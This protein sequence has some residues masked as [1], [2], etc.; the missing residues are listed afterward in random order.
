MSEALE[1]RTKDRPHHSPSIPMQ[2]MD[3][4]YRFLEYEDLEWYIKLLIEKGP[5]YGALL[6]LKKTKILTIPQDKSLSCLLPEQRRSLRR[7]L[8]ILNVRNG[9]G[10]HILRTTPPST[11]PACPCCK[12]W[13]H[14]ALP[15]FLSPS[16]ILEAL[17]LRLIPSS[18]IHALLPFHHHHLIHQTIVSGQS[19]R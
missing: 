2:Y 6:N 7:A 15:S 17:V 3:D 14:F 13:R 5:K 9:T 18:S 1:N 10:L 4:K 11:V 8:S 16:T 12:V 19:T